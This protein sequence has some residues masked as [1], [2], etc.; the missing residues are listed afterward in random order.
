M[1]WE[2]LGEQNCSIARALSVFGDRWTLMIIRDC[3]LGI[4]RF[5]EFLEGLQ[6]SRTILTDRLNRLVEHTVLEKIPY[7]T[8]PTR[9]DY[10]LTPKGLALHPLILIMAEWGDTYY[11]EA[12]GVP[13]IRTHKTC[14]EDFTSKIVCSE[15]G[16]LVTP[17]AVSAYNNPECKREPA[18]KLP[19]AR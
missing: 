7:Q 14:G 18:F 16:E 6:L 1:R 19:I 2:E 8:K 5:D 17:G 3:F 10:K 11:A 9:Y 15:C 4:K 13:I 12:D